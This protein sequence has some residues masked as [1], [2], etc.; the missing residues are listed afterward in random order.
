MRTNF[1]G[2][3]PSY[4]EARARFVHKGA[5]AQRLRAEADSAQR[6]SA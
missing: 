3:D 4:H 6:K 2:P 1:Y 5:P